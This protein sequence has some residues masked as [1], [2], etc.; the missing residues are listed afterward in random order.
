MVSRGVFLVKLK[1]FEDATIACSMS[2]ILFDKK[3]FLVKPWKKNMSYDKNDLSYV[4]VWVKFPQL[5][6]AYWGESSLRKLGGMLGEVLRVDTATLNFDKLMHARVLMDLK[7][8][9][10][11]PEEIYF[12]DDEDTLISQKVIY[13]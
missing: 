4:P 1:S 2:G 6:V 13:D 9:G 8:N 3:P 5:D 7:V 11:F 12:T 10:V